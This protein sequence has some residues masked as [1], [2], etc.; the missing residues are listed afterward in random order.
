M[1]QERKP[2]YYDVGYALASATITNGTTIITTT[3]GA[4]HGLAILA[5][6][7]GATIRLYD[8]LSAATGKILDIITIAANTSDRHDNFI[9]VQARVGIVAFVTLGTGMQG[10]VFFAPKG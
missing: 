10:T 4:Y 3:A 2:S 5:T 7:A 9:P 6:S 1:P 8:S